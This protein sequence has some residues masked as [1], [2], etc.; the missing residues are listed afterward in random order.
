MQSGSMRVELPDG[1][2]WN[3]GEC[4]RRP[5][6]ADGPE[7]GRIQV[8][9]SAFFKKCVLYGD[10][11]FGE[12]YV[13]GDWDTDDIAAVVSWF[14]LNLE[15]APTLSGSRRQSW[16]V[17]WLSLANR[18][19][20]WLRSNSLK[21]TRRNIG[22][23]YDLSNGLFALFLDRSMTYSCAY[24]RKPEMSLQAAQQEKYERL[25]RK[26]RISSS[27]HVLE[28]GCGWGG[29]SRHA[30]ETHGCRVTAITISRQQYEYARRQIDA[31]GL[32]KQVEVR[33]QDYRQ[34]EGR[35]DKIVSIEMLEAVG[36]QFLELFFRKCHALLKRRGLLGLQVITCSDRRYDTLRKSVDWSQKHIFPGSL[37]LSVAA[38]N[39]AV[40]RSGDLFLHDLEDMGPYYARTLSRWHQNFQGNLEAVRQLG[41]DERF[42][43]KWNYYLK[44]CEAAF[45]MRH[46]SVIQAVYTRQN[47]FSL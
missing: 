22:A 36:H 2:V 7:P 30:A 13:D 32:A 40:N 15:T 47:N 39:R 17:N 11:G 41:F 24:F 33:L 44:Y 37:I 12:S 42:I 43:R 20:H 4:D 31:A 27:D 18:W 26:L 8:H 46:N 9:N 14:I 1:K 21:G 10:I 34:V 19:I 23:H 28:L 29:F 5:L 3:F 16:R 38:V 6:E 25:C 35:F 45:A